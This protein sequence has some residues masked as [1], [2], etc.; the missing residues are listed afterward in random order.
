MIA[1]ATPTLPGVARKPR[2]DFPGPRHH[3][4]VRG[5]ARAAVF[6]DRFDYE[7]ILEIVAGAIEEFDWICD[8]YRVLPN[9]LHLLIETVGGGLGEAMRYRFNSR[10]NRVGHV[11]QGPYKD[12]LVVDEAHWVRLASYIVLNPVE[13][14]LCSEAGDWPWSSYRTTSGGRGPERFRVGDRIL[15]YF[16]GDVSIARVRYSSTSPMRRHRSADQVPSGVRD[17]PVRWPRCPSA[18]GSRT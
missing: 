3:V 8:A 1:V 4:M 13:A 12:V 10:Y 11:F 17:G 6:L 9:H 18:S 15:A 7:A 14:G 16:S 5:N 2:I